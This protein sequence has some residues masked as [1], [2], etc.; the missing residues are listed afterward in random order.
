MAY[1]IN[2]P[3]CSRRLAVSESHIG[4]LVR[5]P[6]C[7][8]TS[9]VPDF[10]KA[11]PPLP[12]PLAIEPVPVSRN[13]ADPDDRPRRPRRDDDYDDR[14]RRRRREYDDDYD[15]RPRRRRRSEEGSGMAVGALVLG[16]VGLVTL[17]IPYVNFLGLICA[18][19]ALIF[20]IVARNHPESG[21]MAIAGLVMAII[22]LAIWLG[23]ILFVFALGYH[24]WTLGG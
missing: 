11:V 17:C 9:V 4:Q 13:D 22:T 10:R 1:E 2:C 5:C 14:P 15:D 23:L 20:G 16:I 19:L 8:Q 3:S 7:Q 12:P 6:S 21:G 24:V 18:I